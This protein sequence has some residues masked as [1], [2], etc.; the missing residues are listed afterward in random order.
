MNIPASPEANQ[1]LNPSLPSREGPRSSRLVAKGGILGRSL[2]SH[3]HPNS[4]PTSLSLVGR[5]VID[6]EWRNG[7]KKKKYRSSQQQI[8]TDRQDQWPP[9]RRGSTRCQEHSMLC[10]ERPVRSS[11]NSQT[12]MT[13]FIGVP[14]FAT[15]HECPPSSDFQGA[16]T[17]RASLR[18]G[19]GHLSRWMGRW[20]RRCI[21]MFLSEWMCIGGERDSLSCPVGP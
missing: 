7:S 15:E 8:D 10:Q 20:E 6:R 21:G 4:N 11:N 16:V 13:I 17:S 5:G 14:F 12:V 9:P 3:T 2:H 18:G 19:H 1:P